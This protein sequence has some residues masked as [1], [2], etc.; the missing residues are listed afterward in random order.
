MGVS[1]SGEAEQGYFVNVV[2]FH[3]KLELL[4][5]NTHASVSI[6]VQ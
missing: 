4:G 3:R 1:R 2:T 6:V 5:L